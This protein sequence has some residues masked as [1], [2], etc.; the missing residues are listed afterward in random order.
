[1]AGVQISDMRAV[2]CAALGLAALVG[3]SRCVATGEERGSGHVEMRGP[4]DRQPGDGVLARITAIEERVDREYV[5][6]DAHPQR[7]TMRAMLP[8]AAQ[9][10]GDFFLDAVVAPLVRATL[11]PAP[12]GAAAI[13][14]MSALLGQPVRGLPN[15]SIAP[16]V[17]VPVVQPP[18]FLSLFSTSE[19]VRRTVIGVA[20]LQ[21]MHETDVP[22]DA[23]FALLTR[24][25]FG[26]EHARDLAAALAGLQALPL[27]AMLDW[28][29][30][31]AVAHALWPPG[32]PLAARAYDLDGAA[33]CMET[34]VMHVLA[35]RV[36]ARAYGP[37]HATTA[38]DVCA[39]A[40][41]VF[42]TLGLAKALSYVRLRLYN[43]AAGGRPAISPAVFALWEYHRGRL[44]VQPAAH[45][46][47][48]AGVSW[49]P[50][51]DLGRAPQAHA[52]A[53]VRAQFVLAVDELCGPAA[54][55][56]WVFQALHGHV[57]LLLAS[58]ALR[59]SAIA[60]RITR[61]VCPSLASAGRDWARAQAA[62][63]G[64]GLL[65]SMV[66]FLG[67]RELRRLYW[68]PQRPAWSLGAARLAPHMDTAELLSGM[69]DGSLGRDQRRVLVCAHVLGGG[70]LR[71]DI[72]AAFR[73]LIA[74]S[75]RPTSNLSAAE[76][77]RRLA[78]AGVQ[79]SVPSASALVCAAA[80]LQL[81]ESGNT[82]RLFALQL[83][84]AASPA[85][86]VLARSER[87]RDALGGHLRRLG[88][89]QAAWAVARAALAWHVPADAA[90]A[91]P[92]GHGLVR[93]ETP[94]HMPAAENSVPLPRA[95][96]RYPWRAVQ[97]PPGA[98]SSDDESTVVVQ[99]GGPAG[100]E[101]FEDAA[102][103]YSHA[104]VLLSIERAAIAQAQLEHPPS[105]GDVHH[106]A[107]YALART[108]AL[109]VLGADAALPLGAVMER[110]RARSMHES[111]VARLG[112][113]AML[114][115][116]IGL[117]NALFAYAVRHNAT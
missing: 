55:N 15:G 47:Q 31:M 94:V 57:E 20:A 49:I 44:G 2:R 110:L 68:R 38:R 4:A 11:Q 74:S 100:R 29:A 91:L 6:A 101:S 58:G 26:A 45:T 70:D 83:L 78:S 105:V 32:A 36:L 56:V 33:V 54:E 116:A 71:L 24:I 19:T 35:W 14:D 1:M 34:L 51:G 17:P 30:A 27:D 81:S 102:P 46:A 111:I 108:A 12:A 72:M 3:C 63:S 92:A 53:Y 97:L 43:V 89:S 10:R 90:G 67:L 107:L 21:T 13:A 88:F 7:Y 98:E 112:D 41:G 16:A 117:A 23:Y 66:A 84:L 114:V 18:A 39:A 93:Q 48:D 73:V 77:R 75:F 9:G 87:T 59:T 42:A 8:G 109:D 25:G 104:A 22:L 65:A 28:A 82:A 61:A 86:A 80:E 37:A 64:G 96:L 99:F 115:N 79:L 76:L 106:S 50:P 95:P 60:G 113:R 5:H 40:R 62:A 52:S 69:A 103:V 85:P